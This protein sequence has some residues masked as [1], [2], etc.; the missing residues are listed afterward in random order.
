MKNKVGLFIT[1]LIDFIRPNIAYSSIDLLEKAGYQVE[2]PMP[3]S[4]CGQ[5]GYNSGDNQDTIAIA[6]NTIQLLESFDYVVVPSGSCAGMIKM[7][8]PSLLKND[9]EWFA[10]AAL[11]ASK[12]FEIT[13]FLVDIAKLETL[14][15]SYPHKVTYHDSCAGLRE[16]NV[17]QQPRQ[18]LSLVKDLEF[19]PL[20][21]ANVCCGFGGT[22]CVKYPDI[23]NKMVDDKSQ[24]IITTGAHTLAAGDL[25]CLMNMAGKLSRLGSDIKVYHIAEILSGKTDIAPI[26]GTEKAGCHAS[27]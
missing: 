22:F 1:C 21:D 24:Q 20:A 7:H 11:L 25:G 19:V 6:K 10:R 26:A 9:P 8:Y 5:V 14:D 15:T 16:L 13:S 17:Y 27:R 18:L 23:S 12:T 4:C 3:Q 2:V